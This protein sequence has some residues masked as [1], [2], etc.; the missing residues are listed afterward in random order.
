MNVA[1]VAQGVSGIERK[2]QEAPDSAY[3][4]GVYIGTYLPFVVLIL[5]AY[6]FYL[7]S[8]KRRQ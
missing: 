5:E 3:E 2:M 8:K 4:M 6:L 7:Y 1:L